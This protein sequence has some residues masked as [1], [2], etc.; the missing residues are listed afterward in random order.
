MS[1]RKI[2][3][4]IILYRP[5]CEVDE[6]EVEEDVEELRPVFWAKRANP[7]SAILKSS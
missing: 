5:L 6:V 1:A 7:A 3:D 4:P 2:T